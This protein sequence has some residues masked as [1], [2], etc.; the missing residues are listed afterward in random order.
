MTGQMGM[1]FSNQTK[2]SAEWTDRN[3]RLQFNC[4]P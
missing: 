3:Y 4:K 1:T 2:K